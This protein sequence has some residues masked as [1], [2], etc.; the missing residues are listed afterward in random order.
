[1]PPTLKKLRGHIGLI[2]SVCPSVHYA[3]LGT[4]YLKNCLRYEADIWYT[5]SLPYEDVLMNF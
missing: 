5:V 3:F 1:M 2:I 4:R